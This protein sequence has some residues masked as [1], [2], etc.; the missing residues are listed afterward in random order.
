MTRVSFHLVTSLFIPSS[1]KTNDFSLS[2]LTTIAFVLKVGKLRGKTFGRSGSSQMYHKARDHYASAVTKEYK[3]IS[4]EISDANGIDSILSHWVQLKGKQNK[5]VRLA[6]GPKREHVATARERE[7]W[8]NAYYQKQTTAG[9]ADTI[10][11]TKH[12]DKRKIDIENMFV[13]KDGEMH[14]TTE[15]KLTVAR[16]E[17]L[18]RWR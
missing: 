13:D 12:P 18:A 10:A 1:P 9:G 7:P 3:K 11:T 15:F 8:S 17:W 2:V 5:W 14:T 16:L 6:E 4:S